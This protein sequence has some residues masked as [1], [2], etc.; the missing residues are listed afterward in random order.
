MHGSRQKQLAMLKS[1]SKPPKLPVNARKSEIFGFWDYATG[2][3]PIFTDF[4]ELLTFF[5]SFW[6]FSDFENYSRGSKTSFLRSLDLRGK[7]EL[8]KLA[9][10]R[11]LFSVS[12]HKFF[13][14]ISVETTLNDTQIWFRGIM[15]CKLCENAARSSIFGWKSFNIPTEKKNLARKKT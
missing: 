4:G 7:P 1:P 13:G 14:E 5:G 11:F 10:F 15:T 9:S 3:K 6:D 12:I 2:K 8:S